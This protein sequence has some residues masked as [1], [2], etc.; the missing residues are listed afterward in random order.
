MNILV[1]LVLVIFQWKKYRLHGSPKSWLNLINAW[2]LCI[3]ITE[4]LHHSLQAN[5]SMKNHST[6]MKRKNGHIS[7][8]YVLRKKVKLWW[9]KYLRNVNKMKYLAS[10]AGCGTGSIVWQTTEVE[11]FPGGNVG[12]FFF[13][14]ATYSLLLM[15]WKCSF[16]FVLLWAMHNSGRH[17]SMEVKHLQVSEA[18]VQ[19][20]QWSLQP[21]WRSLELA[22]GRH[23]KQTPC[24]TENNFCLIT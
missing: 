24:H 18:N 22:E 10:G 8:S 5:E 20:T 9:I 1:L 14:S 11:L 23:N 19:L 7:Q 12:F 6:R 13:Y 21:L 3:C 17:K 2:E 15:L 16:C 4:V